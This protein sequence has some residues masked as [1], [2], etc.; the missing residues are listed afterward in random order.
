MT[1]FDAGQRMRESRYRVVTPNWLA[2]SLE[3]RD[4]IPGGAKISPAGVPAVDA[5]TVTVAAAGAAA[6]AASIPLATP[7]KENE[8]IPIGTIMPFGANRFATVTTEAKTGATAIAVEP[9]RDA[10]AAG[11]TG[12]YLGAGAVRIE[13]GTLVGRTLAERDAANPLR[14]ATAA[15]VGAMEEVYL[16]A[17]EIRDARY[18]TDVTLVRHG[19][20]IKENWLPQRDIPA[21]VARV[22]TL[23]QTVAGV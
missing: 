5:V 18:D 19:H 21:I 12:R 1:F 22:R 4:L 2:Q 9:L 23:Y 14:V 6:G 3:P 17:F 20:L 11:D 13:S 15:N 7:L 8:V 16:V 10:L